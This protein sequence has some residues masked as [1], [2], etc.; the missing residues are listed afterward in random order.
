VDGRTVR[1]TPR[2]ESP[3]T[4]GFSP[5]R[6]GPRCARPLCFG[7]SLAT[8]RRGATPPAPPQSRGL[9]IP[10]KHQRP[11]R[12]GRS[13]FVVP[14]DGRARADSL[15]AGGGARGVWS[16]RV[17]GRTVRGTPRDESP[18]TRGFSPPRRGPR[19][20][21]P[22]C[23]GPS[24]ATSRRGATPPAP[25]QSRGLQIP[26]K[27]QRPA[28]AGRSRFVVPRDGRARA[29]SLGAGG[30][31][32]GVW[33]ARVDGRTVRGTPRDE[34]PPTRGF[35][36]PRRGPRC[37]RP[38]CFGPSLATSRRGATPPAPPQSRGL[39][40]PSKH[41]RPARAGRACFM[42]PRDGIE[43]PTRGFSVPCSTT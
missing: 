20:A 29:D 2:D 39:Q 3:P 16:A 7:P 21:R 32:R 30:G 23:F 6:R 18:P 12:A 28:R 24:L 26:S 5:P 13:R 8:S 37:A 9:Q 41:Q 25:P 35:S 15:G 4:R 36:P 14:R 38:L 40:I 34:S 22:L 1:G 31:A 33:S 43:P 10:S 17:D 11:A 19:C 42:V 27:H